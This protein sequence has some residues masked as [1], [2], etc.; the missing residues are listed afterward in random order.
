[1]NITPLS[2]LFT[3]RQKD[4][5]LTNRHGFLIGNQGESKPFLMESEISHI[6]KNTEDRVI[7]IDTFY[8]NADFSRVTINQLEGQLIN[9]NSYSNISLDLFCNNHSHDYFDKSFS[10]DQLKGEKTDLLITIQES[11]VSSNAE[12]TAQM[13]SELYRIISLLYEDSDHPT[14][15]ALLLNLKESEADFSVLVHLLETTSIFHGPAN[16]DL[17]NRFIVFNIAQFHNT[18][19]FLFPVLEYIKAAISKSSQRTWI[20]FCD[21]DTLFHPDLTNSNRYISDFWRRA[22]MRNIVCTGIIPATISSEHIDR[23][24]Y[25]ADCFYILNPSKNHVWCERLYMNPEPFAQLAYLFG[26]KDGAIPYLR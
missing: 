22:R 3:I 9:I 15:E 5:S 12:I 20:Y 19:T 26:D 16:I 25:N 14:I 8:N 21:A 23:L 4:S 7:I 24:L 2:Q 17:E 6:L 10:L 1:M 13:K 11:I 18:N